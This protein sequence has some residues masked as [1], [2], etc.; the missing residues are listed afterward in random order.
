MF[1]SDSKIFLRR[2]ELPRLAWSE[3]FEL[4]GMR[5]GYSDNEQYWFMTTCKICGDS[6]LETYD[7]AFQAKIAHFKHCSRKHGYIFEADSPVQG[8]KSNIQE[9]IIDSMLYDLPLPGYES[10]KGCVKQLID[11][12][13]VCI[14]H[15]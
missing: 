11:D 4:Q 9:V 7:T 3:S 10:H 15:Y 1:S 8:T 12:K 6:D 14:E 13:I 2:L 5:S